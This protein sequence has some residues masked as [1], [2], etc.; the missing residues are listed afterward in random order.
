MFLGKFVHSKTGR[1]FM[2]LLLGLGLASLFRKVCS[3]RNCIIFR[4]PPL[5]KFKDKIYKDGNK[6]YKFNAVATKCD[7]SKK[8]I[9]FEEDNIA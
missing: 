2:S 8:I 9:S 3:D 7:K 1:M 4:A 6:C 5:D